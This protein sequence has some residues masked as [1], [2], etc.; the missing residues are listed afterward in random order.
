M[1]S[2]IATARLYHELFY[3][4]TEELMTGRLRT[5]DNGK[6]IEI[7]LEAGGQLA[8]ITYIYLI[9]NARALFGRRVPDVTS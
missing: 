6:G 4:A 9:I 7:R 2:K 3:S 5:G 1:L 8:S